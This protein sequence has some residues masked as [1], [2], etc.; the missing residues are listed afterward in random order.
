[1]IHAEKDG[2]FTINC[3]EGEVTMSTRNFGMVGKA[4]RTAS[5]AFKDANYAEAIERPQ[6]EE[7]HYIGAILVCLISVTFVVA[8]F[9]HL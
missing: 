5:E 6:K 7:K 4:Y 8:L 2:S 3:N 9:I 1:M